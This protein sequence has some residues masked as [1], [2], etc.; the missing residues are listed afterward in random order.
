MGKEGTDGS[1]MRHHEVLSL[2]QKLSIFSI[3]L[4]MDTDFDAPVTELNI[5]SFLLFL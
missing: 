2:I 1:L 5:Y 3:P 4:N